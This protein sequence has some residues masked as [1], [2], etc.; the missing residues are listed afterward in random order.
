MMSVLRCSYSYPKSIVNDVTVLG[1]DEPRGTYILRIGVTDDLN[2]RFGRFR[3]GSPVPVSRGEVVY[4]GSAMARKGSMTLARRLLRHAT[5]RPPKHPHYL[6]SRLIEALH[7]AELGPK[8]L[9]P[10]TNKKLFWNIDYLLDES[11]AHLQQV[12][13]LRSAYSMEDAVAGMLLADASCQPVAPGLGAHDRPGS[14]HLLQ[15]R[16]SDEWWKALPARFS[17]LL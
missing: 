6:R 4:V 11:A 9:Q 8:D 3:Q 16:A 5:R 14:T 2:V 12:I 10:P 1:R 7:A 15:V 13:I 17:Y